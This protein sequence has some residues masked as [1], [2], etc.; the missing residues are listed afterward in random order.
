MHQKRIYT[1]FVAHTAHARVRRFSLPYSLLY[2]LGILCAVGLVTSIIAVYHYTAMIVKVADF[3]QLKAEN[4]SIKI[5]NQKY[6]LLSDHLA[7]KIAALEV[8][9]MKVSVLSGLEPAEPGSGIGGIGGYVRS[10][11]GSTSTSGSLS[12]LESYQKNLFEL[13]TR[14]RDI[15]MYYEDKAIRSAF[16]PNTWPVKGYLTGGFGYRADPFNKQDPREFHYGID[17]SA[18][19]GKKVVAPADGVVIFAGPRK[20]YGNSI[21][22]DH[23]FGT[24][25]RYGHLSRI[26]VR[27][28][29]RVSRGDVIG[30]VGSTGRSTASHLHYEVRL[31]KRALNPMQFLKSYPKIS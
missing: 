11:R 3:E 7:E 8:A 27:A 20:G 28:G 4:Q 24:T 2:L 18:R 14:Y 21:T 5:E 31:H 22:I 26:V 29:Q 9:S 30:Y 1:C 17:I 16:T 12:N 15:Q 13:E 23:K 10:R 6:Q 25:T 19:Y